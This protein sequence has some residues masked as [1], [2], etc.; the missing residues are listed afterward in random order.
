MKQLNEQQ[1]DNV[2][3][4]YISTAPFFSQIAKTMD[5][6]PKTTE[7][8]TGTLTQSVVEYFTQR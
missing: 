8:L 6:F 1:V 5:W 7:R 2:S 3:G 4:G